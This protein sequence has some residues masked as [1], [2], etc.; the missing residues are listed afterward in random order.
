MLGYKSSTGWKLGGT[1]LLATMV[2]AAMA[3]VAHACAAGPGVAL[4]PAPAAVPAEVETSLYLIGDAGEPAPEGEPVLAALGRDLLAAPGEKVVV[5]LGDNIYPRGMPDSASP[6]RADAERRLLAQVDAARLGGA[7]A[8]FVP[9]NHDWAKLRQDGWDA[10]RR[11]EA[12]LVSLRQPGISMIP[13]GG[14]PGPAVEP[15][16]S[17]V[18]LIA[19]DT[20][21]WLHA[22]PK[23]FHPTSSCAADNEQELT[24]SLRS[25]LA[26]AAGRIVV[27]VAHHPLMAS[28]PHG[29]HFPWTDHVFPLR[30][31]ADW[32]WLPLPIVG[33]AYPLTRKVGLIPQDL[34]HADYK[35]MRQALEEV[36]EPARPLVMAGGHEHVLE[37]L[38]GRASQFV[39][40]SGGG[41]YGHTTPVGHRQET[42]FA[43]SASGFMRLDVT[44][45]RR[46]RL[47]VIVVDAEGRGTEAYGAWLK[48]GS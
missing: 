28:G 37:V 45:D 41:Y 43:R 4:A 32:L 15:L 18:Q 40:V 1:A 30:F 10:I 35:R 25:T 33:S 21:W 48:E 23:P 26:A 9:G 5:F 46:V 16:G 36:L 7:R 13:S 11:Q 20:Q 44:R 34:A 22:G 29:G 38:T 27:V 14:C 2:A 3:L 6:L 8:F 31:L 39:L 47:A 12:Y 24:D 19:L 17:A 42:L